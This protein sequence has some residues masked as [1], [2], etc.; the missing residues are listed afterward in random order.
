MHDQRLSDAF[1]DWESL[2]RGT[3]NF[4]ARRRVANGSTITKIDSQRL[5]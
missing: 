1:V 5:L 3:S 4:N 2:K